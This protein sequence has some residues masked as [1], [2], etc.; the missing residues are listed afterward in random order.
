MLILERRLRNSNKYL[1]RFVRLRVSRKDHLIFSVLWSCICSLEI[2]RSSP[3][4]LLCWIH[5]RL[6]QQTASLQQQSQPHQKEGRLNLKFCNHWD[7]LRGIPLTVT[8]C[9]KVVLP[10]NLNGGILRPQLLCQSFSCTWK[11][12]GFTVIVVTPNKNKSCSF[13]M[14]CELWTEWEAFTEFWCFSTLFYQY[15]STKQIVFYI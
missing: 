7:V 4:A 15:C 6:S 8:G 14:S 3:Q 12:V 11:K 10:H 9:Q 2:R 13:L 1:T 5:Q